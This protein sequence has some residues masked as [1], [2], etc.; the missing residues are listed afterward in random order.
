M[1]L[2]NIAN[3]ALEWFLLSVMFLQKFDLS[4]HCNLV[5]QQDL[6]ALLARDSHLFLVRRCIHEHQVLQL[7]PVLCLG[8]RGI[9]LYQ[10]HLVSRYN[11]EFLSGQVFLDIL[12]HHLFRGIL[13]VQLDQLGLKDLW[14]QVRPVLQ[15]VR[16]FPDNPEDQPGLVYHPSLGVL[17]KKY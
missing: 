6:L 11:Q 1:K 17:V 12:E 10:A 4:Y 3:S 15:G 5:H 7:D 2:L 13:E 8:L 16:L 14:V 9:R